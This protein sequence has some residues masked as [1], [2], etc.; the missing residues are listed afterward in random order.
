MIAAAKLVGWLIA[1]AKFVGWLMA[2]AKQLGALGRWLIAAA[3]Q[4]PVLRG[5][6]QGAFQHLSF[7]G[8]LVTAAVCQVLHD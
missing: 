7:F 8:L 5:P 6:Q 1:A 3:K 2:A 4:P